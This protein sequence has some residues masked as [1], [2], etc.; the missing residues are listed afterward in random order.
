MH[1]YKY[2][3]FWITQRISLSKFMMYRVQPCQYGDLIKKKKKL[4]KLL[5]R[6]KIVND[7]RL[8][9]NVV[10]ISYKTI[11]ILSLKICSLVEYQSRK[12]IIER[13]TTEKWSFSIKHFPTDPRRSKNY[14]MGSKNRMLG[15]QDKKYKRKRL[16]HPIKEP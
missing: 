6:D 16:D 9:N 4:F 12:E 5:A 8:F 15:T 7:F 1:D 13:I 14:D 10:K 3:L 2:I 11:T